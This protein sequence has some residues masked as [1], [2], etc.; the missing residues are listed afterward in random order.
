MARTQLTDELWSKLKPIL[1]ENGI[2][3]MPNLR[4][5]IEGILYKVRVGNPWRDLPP[6]F[7]NWN[8]VFKRFNESNRLEKLMKVFR[9]LVADPDLE[10]KFIDGSIAKAHQ[11]AAGC[12]KSKE[13]GIGKSVG[14]NTSKIHMVVD[15][16][17]LS[18]DFEITEGQIH[19]SQMGSELIEKSEKGKYVV[20]DRGYDAQ[21]LR[22]IVKDRKEIPVIPRKKNSKIGNYDIDWEIY[23][24]RH[25]VENIFARLKHFRSIATRFE[26][27]KSNFVGTV[28]LVCAFLWLKA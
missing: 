6:E 10:F 5:I 9:N 20:A 25:L 16:F 13:N 24:L 4:T 23:K 27:L 1:L 3:D 7:G 14:G 17:G 19:Y 2:F 18:I 12:L 11:H 22:W 28:A 21:Y 8:S 15:S 26:K